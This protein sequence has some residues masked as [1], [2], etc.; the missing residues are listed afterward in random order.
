MSSARVRLSIFAVVVIAALVGTPRTATASC[1]KTYGNTGCTGDHGNGNKDCC[2]NLE[3]TGGTCVCPS[4]TLWNGTTC[5]TCTAE[6]DTAFCSRLNKNCG[7]VTANDNC[8]TTRTVTSCG[9]CTSPSTCGGGGTTNVCGCTAESDTTFCARQGRSCDALS[10]T[11]NCGA[12]RSVTSCGNCL[13]PE[14]CGGGGTAGVCGCS[15][16]SESDAAF[17]TRLGRNCGQ[18]T[19]LNLCGLSR[20]VT[21]CGTCTAPNVCGGATPNVCGPCA[22]ESDT[23]FCARLGKDCGTVSGNDNCGNARTV[24]S[25]GTCGTGKTCGGGGVAN[26]CGC[27]SGGLTCADFPNQC[28]ASLSDGC[29]GTINCTGACSAPQ[30]CGGGGT[31]GYCG[32]PGTVCATYGWTCG[33]APGCA[34]NV[35]CGACTGTDVCVNS[36]CSACIDASYNA[37]TCTASGQ[38]CQDISPLQCITGKC[39]VSEDPKCCGS[40]CD[41]TFTCS[42]NAGPGV[43]HFTGETLIIPNDCTVQ[44]D[45]LAYGFIYR[46]LQS[47]IVVN[48]IINRSKTSQTGVD[49]TLPTGTAMEKFTWSGGGG[50]WATMS[51]PQLSFQGGPF[52]ISDPESVLKVKGI[53]DGTRPWDQRTCFAGNV[54][55]YRLNGVTYDAPV[56]NTIDQPPAMFMLH[57]P[58]GGALAKELADGFG[59]QTGICNPEGSVWHSIAATSEITTLDSNGRPGLNTY[60]YSGFWSSK[61]GPNAT[62]TAQESAVIHAFVDAGGTVVAQSDSVGAYENTAAGRYQST[63]GVDEC[64]P[65]STLLNYLGEPEMQMCPDGIFKEQGGWKGWYPTP[66]PSAWTSSTTNPTKWVRMYVGDTSCTGFSGGLKDGDPQKGWMYYMQGHSSVGGGQHVNAKRILLGVLLKQSIT[67]RTP[68]VDRTVARSAPVVDETSSFPMLYQGLRLVNCDQRTTFGGGTGCGFIFPYYKGTMDV[69]PVSVLGTGLPATTISFGDIAGWATWDP[70]AKLSLQVANEDGTGTRPKRWIFTATGTG[71]SWTRK[72]FT[73]ANASDIAG[74]TLNTG[75]NSTDT[76]AL[77]TAVRTGGFGAI[78][79]ASPAIIE[80]HT[81]TNPL[82]P[83]MAYVAA[84]D[85]MLHALCAQTDGCIV[86]GTTYEAGEE[87]WA[88]IPPTQLSLL[89]SNMQGLDASPRVE[90]LQAI[91]PGGTTRTWRTILALTEGSYGTSVYGLDV[92]DPADPKLLWRAYG[93]PT[94]GSNPPTMGNS[95]GAAL[96]MAPGSPSQL[97]LVWVSSNLGGTAGD[98]G[99]AVYGINAGD[100]T[101]AWWYRHDYLLQKYAGMNI[102]TPNDIPAAPAVAPTVANQPLD[103]LFIGDFDG[104]VHMLNAATG[105]AV[106]TDP[107]YPST[108]VFGQP[109]G[110]PVTVNRTIG[111]NH[112]QAIVGTGGA[113]WTPAGSL[114]DQYY[115]YVI[116]A[117]DRT[118]R[119]IPVTKGERI[120]AQ[121]VV[122][123]Q[124]VFAASTSAKMYDAIDCGSNL[125]FGTGTMYRANL[126]NTSLPV[127]TVNTGTIVGFDIGRKTGTL[128]GGGLRGETAAA[129]NETA[130]G[131]SSSTANLQYSTQGGRP[132]VW[133]QRP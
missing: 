31:A 19:G 8:S 126:E 103:R 10:G 4:G 100:G 38:C 80:A 70:V 101:F 12:A 93:A 54:T 39:C 81:L 21:S 79:H 92:T 90:D 97:A 56:Y 9:T 87:V 17:C 106:G 45:M 121:P 33:V 37:P 118:Y 132:K 108:P 125:S 68:N 53:L 25:C 58:R 109:I 113:D 102:P 29:G 77:I 117:T 13:A 82:R 41:Q 130:T 32:C 104:N 69:T 129:S 48:W 119:A 3:C 49:F 95:N 46:L 22:A 43:Q 11:D 91:W 128:Y 114:G 65:S 18:V 26:V 59:G 67:F 96:G 6:S 86:N 24:T 7:S 55:V 42:G 72:D 116:D 1:G 64:T 120:Y 83:T 62:Y 131:A 14:T 51:T 107:L 28:V 110:A 40:Y 5:A 47:G 73:A 44:P 124:E 122:R 15:G 84:L 16:G 20:T 78:D 27:S 94:S 75:L 61:Y 50:S 99:L 76:A 105:L 63:G 60:T 115:I 36:H 2:G 66:A 52:I 123:G 23:A 74:A 133:L 88:F 98:R 30:T 35:N 127:A 112:L 71:S 89:K 34:N 85:G 57:D 111:T